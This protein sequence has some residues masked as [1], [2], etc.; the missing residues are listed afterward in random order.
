MDNRRRQA[1]QGRVQGQDCRANQEQEDGGVRKIN[2]QSDRLA[3]DK[4][5]VGK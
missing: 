3:E 5:E 2:V 4:Q 1:D